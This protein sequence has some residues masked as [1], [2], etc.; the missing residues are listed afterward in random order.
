MNRNFIRKNRLVIVILLLV[1]FVF[2]IHKIKPAFL[3]EKNGSIRN[4]GF[5]VQSKTIVPLWLL[6]IIM[7]ILFYIFV[8]FYIKF[9]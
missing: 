2:T 8:D 3:Y 6:V 5:G 1:I 4:F 7:S 9:M